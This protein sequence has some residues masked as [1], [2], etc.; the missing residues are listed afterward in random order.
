MTHRVQA[1]SPNCRAA[2]VSTALL[3]TLAL[4]AVNGMPRLHNARRIADDA[5]QIS[6]AVSRSPIR[7]VT[8]RDFV[9][10]EQLTIGQ[11]ILSVGML[12]IDVLDPFIVAKGVGKA[13][14]ASGSALQSITH[15]LADNLA[16][17]RTRNALQ[18]VADATTPNVT[19]AVPT[20]RLPAG[21]I[22]RVGIDGLQRT[23]SAVAD[24]GLEAVAKAQTHAGV[25]RLNDAVAVNRGA[26]PARFQQG[27]SEGATRELPRPSAAREAPK[28]AGDLAKKVDTE[29]M[30]LMA[31]S[32]AEGDQGKIVWR[33]LCDECFP[34]G[35]RVALADGRWCA[36]ENVM[37]GDRILTR[38]QGSD[39]S[40]FISGAVSQVFTRVAQRVVVLRLSAAGP[41]VEERGVELRATPEHPFWLIGHGWMAAQD[42]PAGGLIAGDTSSWRVVSVT[43]EATPQR[44]YNLEVPGTHTYVVAAPRGPP[45]G[46]WVHNVCTKDEALQYLKRA[47]MAPFVRLVVGKAADA[48]VTYADRLVAYRKMVAARKAVLNLKRGEGPDFWTLTAEQ[49]GAFAEELFGMNLGRNFP[50]IDNWDGI[51][52]KATSLKTL[53]LGSGF[54]DDAGVLDAT[55]RKYIDDLR[56]WKSASGSTDYRVEKQLV[57]TD[58]ANKRV[59][60]DL[61]DP[62]FVQSKELILAVPANPTAAGIPPGQRALLAKLQEYAAGHN[63]T[64][65]IV[66]IP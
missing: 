29:A 34:G 47:D 57:G 37:V 54:Y 50:V 52:R 61:A 24:T 49:R 6:V 51:A 15:G 1:P 19:Q 7:I 42:L 64:L 44:V 40:P 27:V 39:T 5:Q 41:S 20:A 35:T 43:A 32:A 58:R 62:A 4:R 14:T 65:T 33:D 55:V 23:F 31:R 60:I 10:G 21:V 59:E 12:G 11:R 36:I 30:P 45:A 28:T 53:N 48:A 46:V 16:S 3:A 2:I 8:G 18:E 17:G 56:D 38:D 26:Q 25:G 22:T 66:E 13:I 63:I 9:T